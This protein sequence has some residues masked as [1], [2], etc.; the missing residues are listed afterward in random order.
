[1][2]RH[3]SRKSEVQRTNP[4]LW[5]RSK[6]QAVAKMGGKHSARA[7]QYAVYLYKKAGGKYKGSKPSART[8]SLARWTSERWGYTS[9][10]GSRYLPEKVRKSL[11]PEEKR[12]TNAAK[13]R[14]SREGRQW[15]RQP[16]DV[17]RKA[18][19]IRRSM[20]WA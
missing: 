17:A 8:N 9:G 13:R 14:A 16:K 12:R 7:M 5:E 6:K 3:S 18:S 19:R 2:A 1:M 4:A 20:R 11:T 15:S 10:K